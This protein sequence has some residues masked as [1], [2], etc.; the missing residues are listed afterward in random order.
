MVATIPPIP[1]KGTRFYDAVNARYAEMLPFIT[2]TA[3]LAFASQDYEARSVPAI[4][5]YQFRKTSAS[6]IHNEPKYRT[7]NA[8]W[9]AHSPRSVADRHYN[10]DDDTIL[11]DCVAW[12]YD[13]IFDSKAPLEE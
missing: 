2:K 6:L 13:K 10:A 1:K 3:M 7:F 12:L 8:L 11:D 9:L 4:S 5:Y